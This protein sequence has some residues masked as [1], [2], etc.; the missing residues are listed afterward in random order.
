MKPGLLLAFGEQ[1]SDRFLGLF[2]VGLMLTIGYVLWRARSM[3]ARPR[4]DRP[5]TEQLLREAEAEAR[6]KAA[7]RQARDNDHHLLPPHR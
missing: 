5:T 7:E 2:I 3:A 1:T 4:G 6:R